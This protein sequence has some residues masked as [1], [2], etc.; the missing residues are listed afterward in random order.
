MRSRALADVVNFGKYRGQPIE[1]L[2]SDRG[3]CDWL[4]AQPW[5]RDRHRI[6]RKAFGVAR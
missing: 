4:M 2:A 6:G 1:I 3:Y 5:F